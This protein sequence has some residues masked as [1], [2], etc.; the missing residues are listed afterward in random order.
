[1]II[2]IR[3]LFVNH[4]VIER[5]VVNQK[6]VAEALGISRA[7]VQKIEGDALK[8]LLDALKAR[9]INKDDLLGGMN[10]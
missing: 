5:C 7:L 6:E 10:G 4:H 2:R 1:M 3:R 8:K 9:K